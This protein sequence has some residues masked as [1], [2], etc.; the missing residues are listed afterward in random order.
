MFPRSSGILLHLTSLPGDYGIGSMGREARH[1]V[2]FLQKAGQSYWQILPLVPPG[3]GNSPYMS[4]SSAAGNP[5][6]IDLPTLAEEGLLQWSDLAPYHYYDVDRVNYGWV[7]E[8]HGILLH[9]A[10]DTARTRPDVMAQVAAF[11]AEEGDWLPD[12][13]LFLACGEKFSCK[14]VDW[15]DADLVARQPAAL[16]AYRAELAE[17]IGYHVFCQ[18]LFHRQWSALRRYANERG[19]KFIGDI[20]FYVSPDSVDVWVHPELFQVDPQTRRATF[21]AGV[22]ADMFSA[23]GQLWGNP[24][25][26]W[27]VH[28]ADG[29]QWWCSRIRRTSRFYDVIRIDHFRGFHTYWEIPATAE[30]ALEGRW[31]PGPGMALLDALRQ[32][33]PEA[34]F[35]AEDLGDISEEVYRFIQGSGLPGMR[36]LTDAFND[37]WGGSSFLPHHCVPD[38][39]MYTGTHD[40]PTFL[41]WLFDQAN[42][43]QRSYAW[44]YLRLREDE[45]LSW[46]VIAGAW[47]SV[48]SLAMAPLQDVLGL[49]GDARMNTPGTEGPHNWSWRVR[50]EALNDG[51][52]GKLRELTWLYGRLR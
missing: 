7:I 26:D 10:Y 20:P 48:C 22:P 42:D 13:A 5:L 24:L 28:A 33:V 44:R 30:S 3:E 25:Y 38:A 2:D 50:M 27:P 39:V 1:F 36:V 8:I 14:L 31:R 12:L 52:A 18:Y 47:G 45:G 19:I 16:E 9:R 23:T 17:P 49:G 15:P 40:T 21:V 37:L 32:K 41:Q 11:T 29:Y 34:E 51:V 6:L 43:D 4:P 35:I 46:G